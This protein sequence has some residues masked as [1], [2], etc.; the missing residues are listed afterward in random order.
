MKLFLFILLIKTYLYAGLPSE[1][2]NFCD[3]EMRK[4][5]VTLT[6]LAKI[7]YKSQGG[8]WFQDNDFLPQQCQGE[9]RDKDLIEFNKKVSSEQDIRANKISF[10]KNLF[11]AGIQA[12]YLKLLSEK[13]RYCVDANGNYSPLPSGVH[14]F[15]PSGNVPIDEDYVNEHYN[16]C[17][18]L[19]TWYTSN[20]RPRDDLCTNGKD[21]GALSTFQ[22]ETLP[23]FTQRNLNI[24]IDEDIKKIRE[25]YPFLY[26]D[27][28][29]N[30]F[31]ELQS[32]LEKKALSLLGNTNLKDLDPNNLQKLIEENKDK[33]IDLVT[34]KNNKDYDANASSKLFGTLRARF[35]TDLKNND[36]AMKEVC[37]RGNL[38]PY[39]LNPN[40]VNTLTEKQSVEEA[41]K[42]KQCESQ[43]VSRID[44]KKKI[45]TGVS[46]AAGLVAVG[47]FGASLLLSAGATTLLVVTSVGAA[48]GLAGTFAGGINTYDAFKKYKAYG[49][50]RSANQITAREVDSSRGEFYKDAAWSTVDAI[51]TFGD[52]GQI[53]KVL[54]AG[55]VARPSQ[56][57]IRAVNALSGEAL[58]TPND[59]IR[60]MRSA[61]VF[62]ETRNSDFIQFMRN[63]AMKHKGIKFVEIENAILKRLNDEIFK[64][65]DIAS[66]V[67]Q[68]FHKTFFDQLKKRGLSGKLVVSNYNDYK[69]IRLAIPDNDPALLKAIEEAYGDTAR[70]L[71][72]SMKNPEFA[73]Y[74]SSTKVSDA[75]DWHLMGVGDSPREAAYA[76][77]KARDISRRMQTPV[78]SGPRGPPSAVHFKDLKEE[79]QYSLN[80]IE[81][82]RLSIQSKLRNLKGV[83]QCGSN[84]RCIPSFDTIEILRKAN[85]M[86][87]DQAIA[88]IKH[89]LANRF[90]IPESSIEDVAINDM[91]TYFREC[92]YFSA[93]VFKVSNGGLDA[94]GKA[95]WVL[96]MDFSGQ[97]TLNAQGVMDALNN[98][99]ALGRNDDLIGRCFQATQTNFDEATSVLVDKSTHAISAIDARM[100]PKRVSVENRGSGDDLLNLGKGPMTSDDFLQILKDSSGGKYGPNAQRLALVPGNFVDSSGRATSNIMSGDTRMHFLDIAYGLEKKMREELE[101]LYSIDELKQIG[102]GIKISPE[103]MS[104]G[105]AEL[106]LAGKISPEAS[107]KI[108]D[109]FKRVV[110]SANNEGFVAEVSSRAF[111]AQ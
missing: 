76:A 46:I 104:F 84:G 90:K 60:W 63:P 20:T 78:D 97:G 13:A 73:K 47:T 57:A 28:A 93:P 24:L 36:V 48:S 89:R 53:V 74:L 3:K 105:K 40:I 55:Q 15:L 4:H 51:G 61:D 71:S 31:S 69:S 45:L 95:D 35:E 79:I 77:R 108:M 92:D 59:F 94:S 58:D 6:A 88:Y 54:K 16:Y 111:I 33:F 106:F 50:Q 42:I 96:G 100:K 10:L 91:R 22:Q 64:N 75:V 9:L 32:I 25:Y 85:S 107:S 23:A 99:I 102:I 14:R 43:I 1:Q 11:S 21:T 19:Y 38:N 2:L 44:L 70:I 49:Y 17:T 27:S 87:E 56:G 5:V 30:S 7:N 83:L 80:T 103:S 41:K 12:S 98:Q 65:Q 66:A 26:E 37:S 81:A 68:Y 67:G 110:G 62:S 18:K 39:W 86:P 8:G 52:L 29:S 34:N 101:A 82:L 72:D 109:T